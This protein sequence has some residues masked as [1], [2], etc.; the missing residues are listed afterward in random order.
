MNFINSGGGVPL[1][2]GMIGCG[3][4]SLRFI[5]EC[6]FADGAG[7]TDCYHPCPEKSESAR[8]FRGL[9]PEIR[10]AGSEEELYSR[11]DAVYIASPH[12]THVPY[13]K[14]ALEAGCHVLCE[15]P[16][17]L[18]KRDA[19]ELFSLAGEKGL[20]LMEGIKTAYCPGFIELMACCRSGAV[21]TVTDV[22]AV[23][24][25]LTPGDRREW[26]DREYGGSF[27]E[28]GS[29]VL[30]PVI[31]LLGNDLS[32][33]FS[34]VF[35]DGVDSFTRVHFSGPGCSAA[36][37]TGIGVKSLGELVISGTEGFITVPA[38]WWKTGG[39]EIGY[40]DPDRKKTISVPFEG[41]GLR[42]EIADFYNRIRGKAGQERKLLPEESIKIAEI[43]EDFREYQKTVG[44]SAGR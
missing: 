13:V 21:G 40:E 39:F 34:S 2:I 32:W 35:R 23:F 26:R 4:I 42:Y 22:D 6:A 31:R 10:M 18:R 16:M 24:T 5:K 8:R 36:V 33:R 3:R 25:R 30:L 1:R 43:M 17:S 11:V 44:S 9:H 12:H 15:K 19:E 41:D 14:A 37:R 28:L 7:V 38:P 20:V 27:T 29:Y